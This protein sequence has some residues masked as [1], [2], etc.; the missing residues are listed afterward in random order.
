[1]TAPPPV[2]TPPRATIGQRIRARLVAGAA[3][4]LIVLPEAPVNA[5]GNAVGSL[6]YRLAPGR[7]VRARHNLRRVARHL[8]E[9]GLGGQ[10]IRAAATD[11]AAL[12]G[13]VRA[14]FRQ[15]VRY[16]LDMARLP[17]QSSEDL[18]RRLIV[19]TPDSVADAF[20]K[21]GPMVF[22][23]MHFGA[24]EY[25]A[26]FAVARTGR[27][28]TA[29]METLGDPALQAWIARTRG[30]VG[31][32]IVGLRDARRALNQALDDGGVVGMVADRNVAGG[33]IDVPFF[34]E[35]APL[36]MGPGLLALE[37]GLP[38]W[39]AAVRRA[40]GGRYRGQLR[41]VDFPADGTR[42]ERLTAAMTGVA[43]AM[44]EAIAEAPDQWWSVFSPIWP[45]LDPEARTGTGRL[46]VE[47]RP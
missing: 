15:A 22:V 20:G 41:R 29:P 1:M 34:G 44:E 39:V 12:E 18:D 35:T 8:V 27:N 43:R 42:R 45:D 19:E 23:A 28:V 40:E 10:V 7:A 9:R 25:P 14:A 6:W 33:T 3:W 21:P 36:P 38:I 13:V 24:V 37:R 47:A 4:L 5:V 32:D 17:G 31:V 46:E 30:S 11:D 26:M 2:A 16:Y